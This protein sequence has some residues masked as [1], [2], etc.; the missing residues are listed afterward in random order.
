MDLFKLQE[1]KICKKYYALGC[2]VR[3]LRMPQYLRYPNIKDAP[4]LM[5]SKDSRGPKI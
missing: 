4:I 5:M 3:I 1:K 2:S